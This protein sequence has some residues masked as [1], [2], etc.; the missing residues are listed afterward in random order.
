MTNTPRSTSPYR[1]AA[2]I[3]RVAV[4]YTF[5][6]LLFPILAVLLSYH[7]FYFDL[8]S[9][10]QLQYS[11]IWLISALVMVLLKFYREAFAFIFFILAFSMPLIYPSTFASAP[12][13]KPEIYFMNTNAFR[14]EA[15]YRQMA[16]YISSYRPAKIALVEAHD[17]VVEELVQKGY[18]LQTSYTRGALSCAILSEE[19]PIRSTVIQATEYP[20]CYAQY[21]DYHLIVVHPIPPLNPHNFE[22]EKRYFTYI[23]EMIEELDSRDERFVLVGDFNS[24]SYS[25]LFSNSFHDYFVQNNYSWNSGSLL[26]IP[27]DHAMSN[28]EINVTMGDTV[29]SDH[30]GLFVEI[31]Q[32]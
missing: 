23:E 20:I 25:Q 3:E 10:F 17:D 31:D 12:I 15:E 24:T 1:L 28:S 2:Q 26:T 29:F 18:P 8:F 5:A 22:R 13:Y 16:N 32:D 4:I 21:A 9:H 11:V 7:S 14:T 6:A 19:V 30:R 27:I